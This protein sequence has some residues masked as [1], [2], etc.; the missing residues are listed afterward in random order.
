LLAGPLKSLCRLA[1][2]T[3]HDPPGAV[4]VKVVEVTRA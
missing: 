1:H 2:S 3:S 4:V